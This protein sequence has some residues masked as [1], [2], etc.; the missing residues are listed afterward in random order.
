M[1]KQLAV[2]MD[3]YPDTYVGWGPEHSQL[4]DA[5]RYRSM[6]LVNPRRVSPSTLVQMGFTH[7]LVLVALPSLSEVRWLVPTTPRAAA[8]HGLDFYAPAH[9]TARIKKDIVR[10]LA[11]CQQL[12]R[13]GDTLVLARRTK[14]PLEQHIERA[15]NLDHVIV[16]M[17]M[18]VAQEHRK[19]TLQVMSTDGRVVAYAKAARSAQSQEAVSHE[20]GWLKRLARNSLLTRSVPALIGTFTSD[21]STTSI[22]S[23]GPPRPGPAAFGQPHV[24]FLSALATSTGQTVRFRESSMWRNMQTSFRS[25]EPQLCDAW[26]RR[27]GSALRQIDADLGSSELRLSVAHRDFRPWNT[28]IAADGRL[29]VYDWE[30]AQEQMIP[31][32]DLIHF[33][34]ES[35][36]RQFIRDEQVDK[37][38][39][40]ILNACARWGPPLG[41]T[42]IRH[43]LLAY[44]VERSI[45]R[46]R[47][48][49]WR[50]ANENDPLVGLLGALLDRRAQWFVP[51]N[52][53]GEA[54]A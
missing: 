28:R 14:S 16:S 33:F 48:A 24:D 3:G 30:L 49:L 10:L 39:A 21:D 20:A 2:H 29:F 23:P 37:V 50:R 6:V 54:S 19:A 8:V 7:T 13:I 25:L 45:L 17:S 26:R 5:A 31:T 35:Q 15:T 36:A 44:L 52:G 12:G 42:T 46:L 1:R 22:Q 27:L 11:R 43:F 41:A 38:T 53:V 51:I 34:V 40:R 18:G 32:Y 47:Y 9:A 4:P